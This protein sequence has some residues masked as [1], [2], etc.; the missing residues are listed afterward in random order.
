MINKCPIL[1]EDIF[2]NTRQKT[3]AKQGSVEAF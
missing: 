3:Q 2:E 1:S